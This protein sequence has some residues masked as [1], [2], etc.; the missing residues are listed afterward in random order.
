MLAAPGVDVGGIGREF[1]SR[2]YH[3]L[4]S[5]HMDFFEGDGSRVRPVCTV[6][7]SSGILKTIG[8]MIGHSIIMSNIG[9]LLSRVM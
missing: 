8:N 5:G 6:S 9:F 7:L 3:M 4:S 2:V 1:L